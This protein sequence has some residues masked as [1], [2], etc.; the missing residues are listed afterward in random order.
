M[1]KFETK[2]EA[3]IIDTLRMI[4]L[5]IPHNKLFLMSKSG[6]TALFQLGRI[7]KFAVY[8]S[9]YTFAIHL[10]LAQLARAPIAIG[11][12]VVGS[13][14]YTLHELIISRQ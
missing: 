14:H 8:I 10:G 11:E 2:S 12:D 3:Q 6:N 1:Y 9:T 5:S 4:L 13:D 7:K